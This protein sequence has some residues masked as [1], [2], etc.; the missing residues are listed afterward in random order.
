MPRKY[1]GMILSKAWNVSLRRSKTPTTAYRSNTCFFATWRAW[2][3]PKTLR[4]MIQFNQHFCLKT[5]ATVYV[6]TKRVMS[7]KV[8]NC[9]IV[10]FAR[11]ERTFFVFCFRTVFKVNE[12]VFAASSQSWHIPRIVETERKEELRNVFQQSDANIPR[13]NLFNWMANHVEINGPS[14]VVRFKV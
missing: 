11:E 1:S 5:S 9:H 10:L 12:V 3:S 4:K 13:E 2:R 8:R 14:H 6:R 7:A